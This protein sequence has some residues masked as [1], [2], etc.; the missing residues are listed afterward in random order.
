MK[1]KYMVYNIYMEPLP[2][3]V[4]PTTANVNKLKI[5]LTNIQRFNDL[6]YTYSLSK[7]ANAFLLLSK[8]DDNDPG[9]AIG[10]NLLCG[11]MIGIG[12]DFGIIGCV[13]ANYFCALVSQFSE[14]NPPSLLAHF[15]SYVSRI[16]ATSLEANHMIATDYSDPINNWYTVK[17]GSF[18]TFSGKKTV[19]CCLGQVAAIDFPNETDPLFEDM[20]TKTLF[21]FD[22]T[23]WWVILTQCF[24]INVWNS[25]VE[26]EYLVSQYSEDWINDYC[27]KLNIKYPST[28]NTWEIGQIRG[29]SGIGRKKSYYIVHESSLGSPPIHN[30]DQTISDAAARYLFID[31]IPG[32]II[33]SEGLFNRDFVFHNF[34]MKIVQQIY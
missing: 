10:I 26:P 15:A 33:N 31:S 34:G 14:K 12:G 16:Q 18:N 7:C 20:M 19:S 9:I 17:S 22:Q 21:S 28:N 13:L 3:P 25:T 6:F 29:L 1:N 2:N 4:Q 23:L 27:K 30:N 5:N 24:Q 32:D 11:T 8:N